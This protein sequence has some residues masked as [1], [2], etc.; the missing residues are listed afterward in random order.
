MSYV[1]LKKK[2]EEYENKGIFY[3]FSKEQFEK[4]MKKCGYDENTKLVQDG[5]GGYG[6]KEAFDERRNFYKE[7][8]EE[9]RKTCTPEEIFKYE[10]WNHECEYTGEWDEAIEM[11]KSYFPKFELTNE[12]LRSLKNV[13]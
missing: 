8:E 7:V 11:T 9:I 5:M 13:D 2:F 12:I 6:T 4:G 3:A 1:Q 10:Y